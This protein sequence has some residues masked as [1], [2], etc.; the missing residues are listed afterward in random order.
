APRVLSDGIL[1][2]WTG[3][4]SLGSEPITPSRAAI[5][6]TTPKIRPSTRTLHQCEPNAALGLWAKAPS[7]PP[8][9]PMIIT[10]QGKRKF[11]VMGSACV[12]ETAVALMVTGPFWAE[13]NVASAQHWPF[14]I[15]T[16]ESTVP[17]DTLKTTSVSFTALITLLASS[18]SITTT[19]TGLLPSL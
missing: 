9:A 8:R 7:N 12:N 1:L 15:V 2:I 10:A 18:S 14:K 16:F 17:R 13:V 6:S 4:P 19:R 11:A 3:K 5:D